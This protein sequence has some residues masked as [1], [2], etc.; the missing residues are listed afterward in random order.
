MFDRTEIMTYLLE[1]RADP[2]AKDAADKTAAD[3]ATSMGATT[4]IA[5]WKAGP[6]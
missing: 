2:D 6:S 1:Q 5:T 4:A 3:L